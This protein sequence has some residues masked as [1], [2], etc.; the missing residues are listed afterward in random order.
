MYSQRKEFPGIDIA[1]LICSLL[2]VTIHVS[3]FGKSSAVVLPNFFLQHYL[4]R[5]A[6]P[7]F[8]IVSG[9][10]L[11]RKTPLNQFSLAPTWTFLRR[12][13]RLYCLWCLLYFPLKLHRT[14]TYSTHGLA[15]N[16]FSLVRDFLFTG[17]FDHLWYLNAL[18]VAVVIVSLLLSK[19]VKP[20]QIFT[21]GLLLQIAGLLVQN[22]VGLIRPL[23]T[24]VP[25]AWQLLHL[26]KKVFVTTRNGLFEGVLYVSVGMLFAYCG[27]P[28]QKRQTGLG[29][30]ASMAFLLVEA[31]LSTDWGSGK[32]WDMYLF[33]LPA[34]FFLFFLTAGVTMEPKPIY[35]SMRSFSS[36][37]F[38]LHPMVVSVLDLIA[39]AAGYD[40]KATL[41]RFPVVLLLTS[42]LCILILKTS[43]KKEGRWLRRLY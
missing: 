32:V 42:A 30:L 14:L 5:I 43:D 18:M 39:E 9:F 6:V 26:A 22:W 17:G 23:Q 31:G 21:L 28:L 3:P 10:F 24:T 29:F 20:W 15:Y 33:V 11:Y 2:V 19:K 38:Y 25:A 13:L 40:F 8:F 35:R 37:L 12:I 1:R 27:F 7:Y 36:L 41:L 34:D 16:I 4:A